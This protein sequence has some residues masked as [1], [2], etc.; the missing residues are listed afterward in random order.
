MMCDLIAR[1][2][3]RQQS[4]TPGQATHWERNRD[5]IRQKIDADAVHYGMQP[6]LSVQQEMFGG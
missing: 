2:V 5:L 6:R 3:P 1:K 4:M